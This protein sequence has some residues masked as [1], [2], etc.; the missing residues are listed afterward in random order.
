MVTKVVK[1]AHSAWLK[2]LL[3]GK[4]KGRYRINHM[5]IWLERDLHPLL[6]E[7][8]MSVA[9]ISKQ[10]KKVFREWMRKTGAQ[11]KSMMNEMGFDS[12]DFKEDDRPDVRDPKR[13]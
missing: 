10:T 6:G 11:R 5:E 3:S 7:D 12:T 13:S 2:D 1:H 4:A 8:S 9:S